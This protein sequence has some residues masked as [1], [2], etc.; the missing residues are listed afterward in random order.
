M[1]AETLSPDIFPEL[2]C[3]DVAALD[4]PVLLLNGELS[5]RLFHLINAELARCLPRA[6]QA[7][8]PLTSHAIHVGNP[9]AYHAAVR[10]FL[11]TP[12]HRKW[13]DI[14][15]AVS[16]PLAGEDAQTWVSSSPRRMT[17][18]ANNKS[19]TLPFPDPRHGGDP[20]HTLN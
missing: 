16:Y 20:N 8:I 12:A 18:I 10:E 7:V 11:Q 9:V 15:G 13:H 5:P 17:R 1:R 2:T 14:S 6:A 4:R 3:A 19:T